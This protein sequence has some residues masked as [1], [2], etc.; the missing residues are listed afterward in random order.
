MKTRKEEADDLIEII[1]KS[2][3]QYQIKNYSEY[4]N[5]IHVDTSM[6]ARLRERPEDISLKAFARYK[7][8]ITAFFEGKK[9][10]G[11]VRFAK[12]PTAD[13]ISMFL[14]DLSTLDDDQLSKLIT[15]SLD[16]LFKRNQKFRKM[17]MSI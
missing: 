11:N 17:I 13:Q 14:S 8:K 16:V 5:K 9:I 3:D 15:D 10:Q 1:H 4:I 6:I 12:K 7:Y 2:M